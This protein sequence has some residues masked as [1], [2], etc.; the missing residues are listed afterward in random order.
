VGRLTEE[1]GGLPVCG[2]EVLQPRVVVW[3][4]GYA[5]DYGWIELPV[6][7]ARGWPRHRRGVATDVTGLYFVGLRFQHRLTSSLLGGVGADATF[8]A[9]R[10]ARRVGR[11][12][13]DAV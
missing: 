10:I 5:P 13:L 3:C 2:G 12:L 7:D 9:E 4:T 1:R 11:A 6:L 8:V